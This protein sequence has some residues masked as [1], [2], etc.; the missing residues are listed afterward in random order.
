M[1]TEIY[2][3]S[4]TGNGLAVAKKLKED[5]NG[6][7]SLISIRDCVKR[8]EEIKLNSKKTGLI[9]PVYSYGSPRIVKNFLKLISNVET[10]YFFSIATCGGNPAG[11]MKLMKGLL[12]NKGI[13]L[14]SGFLVSMGRPEGMQELGIV[15]LMQK[16]SGRK[17]RS[18]MERKSEI[19]E[20]INNSKIVKEENQN[21]LS[22]FLGGIVHNLTGKI[23]PTLD[24]KF[25]I[26]DNCKGCGVCTKVCPVN[27][28]SIETNKPKWHNSCEQCLGCI[29]WCPSKAIQNCEESINHK[30]Y[31]HPN[32]TMKEIIC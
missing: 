4:A 10:D 1:R 12:K 30:K 17:I 23:F 22:S 19:I 27:N 26:N 24:S 8:G 25:F 32:V 28:I 31:H 3:F 9:Y 5:L 16:I 21:L 18:W 29:Q 14:N 20:I 11:S 15:K 2:Y 6:D 7:V 13:K